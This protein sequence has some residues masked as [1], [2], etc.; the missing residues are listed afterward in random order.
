MKRGGEKAGMDS[1]RGIVQRK[2]K[3]SWNLIV[4]ILG[5]KGSGGGK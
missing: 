3:R 2:T 4:P 1:D 5:E